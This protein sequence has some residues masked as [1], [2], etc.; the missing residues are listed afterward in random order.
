LVERAI[1]KFATLAAPSVA[2]VPDDGPAAALIVI[3]SEAGFVGGVNTRR[4][5]RAQEVQ[6]AGEAPVIGGR[7][8][9]IAAAEGGIA[10]GRRCPRPRAATASPRI[11][12]ACRGRWRGGG[13]A[14]HLGAP[15]RRGG[16]RGRPPP[17]LAARRSRRR[18]CVARRAAAPSA[19]RRPARGGEGPATEHRFAEIA[20][21]PMGSL[22]AENVARLRAIDAALRAIDDGL[23]KLT[24]IERR[25]AGPDHRRHP[26]RRHRG[27]AV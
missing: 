19:A 12:D 7:R 23:E 25:E 10:P 14:P 3:A 6:G 18:D 13:G 16:S 1:R 27:R 8:A 21:A 2:P 22:A 15:R 26:R 9:V 11:P 17:D 5:D 20:D 24:R 4:I